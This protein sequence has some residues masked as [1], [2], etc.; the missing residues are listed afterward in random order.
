M[1]PKVDAYLTNCKSW[2]SEMKL[3]REI[4]LSSELIE[5]FKWGKPCYVI[6]QNN[7]LSIAPMKESCAL[8][9]FKGA[10]MKD[11]KKILLKP[12]ENTRAGR[13]IKFT[14]LK[15]IKELEITLKE[16]ILEAIEIEK[17]GLKVVVEDKVGPKLPEEFQKIL[18][19]NKKFS[20]AFYSL[21]PG[22]QR[23]YVMFFSAPKQSNT[24]TTRVEKYM[25]RIM[26]GKGL[27]DCTCGLS[28]KMP[29]CDGSHKYK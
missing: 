27:N 11:D 19:A 22:R 23:G 17:A 5:E 6:E 20:T 10:L 16:Y 9:F 14:S 21:T 28:K 13:W 26:D 7:V 15:E 2:K 29:A 1:N 18:D 3:L 24:R 25:Q 12:G 8:A 4:V